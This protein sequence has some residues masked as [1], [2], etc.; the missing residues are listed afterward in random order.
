MSRLDLRESFPISIA[1]IG[2]GKAEIEL[3]LTEDEPHQVSRIL[4]GS[5]KG[6]HC[7]GAN[8]RAAAEHDTRGG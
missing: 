6:L 4:G 1:K 3:R 8:D 7:R 2:V 5:I